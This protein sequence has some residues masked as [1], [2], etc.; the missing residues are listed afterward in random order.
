MI[1]EIVRYTEFLSKPAVPA[2]VEDVQVAQDLVDTVLSLEDCA[3]LAANQ[4]GSDKAVIAIR[5]DDNTVSI[6]FNPKL[7]QA[8]QP[9][10]VSESC[11]SLDGESN[12]KRFYVI[13][14]T[15]DE[16]VDGKFERRQARFLDWQAQVIQHCID[17]CNGRLV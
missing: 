14:A 12:L 11:L 8:M 4:I 1:K 17:H 13:K 3:C 2:T 9:Y 10:P 16:L 5:N 7:K 15:W 6:M